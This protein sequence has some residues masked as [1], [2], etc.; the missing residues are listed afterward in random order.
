MRD[1]VR[2]T[3]FSAKEP[4]FVDP[5]EIVAI[6]P[7]HLGSNIVLQSGVSISVAESVEQC[8]SMLKQKNTPPKQDTRPA[9][10][11]R[12]SRRS[13]DNELTQG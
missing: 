6:H 5:E 9:P 8:Y 4:V 7:H 10:R 11:P 12:L 3:Y 2:L 13:T 1:L